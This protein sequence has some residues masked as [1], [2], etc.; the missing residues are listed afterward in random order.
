MSL[1]GTTRL[2]YR[3]MR[4]LIGSAGFGVAKSGG[5][6]LASVRRK[7]KPRPFESGQSP[8]YLQSQIG[9]A[10]VALLRH[11]VPWLPKMGVCGNPPVEAEVS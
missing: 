8:C 7:R 4:D 5:V 9:A 2:E 11:F 1:L 10:G 6:R 3:V